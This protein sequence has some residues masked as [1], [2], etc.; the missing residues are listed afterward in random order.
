M[1]KKRKDP[2]IEGRGIYVITTDDGFPCKVGV[3]NDLKMRLGTLQTGNWNRLRA[4]WFTFVVNQRW[5]GSS[6]NVWAAASNAADAFELQIHEKMREL[7]LHL[8]GEWF[9]VDE[10]DCVEVIK[11]VA[12]DKHMTLTGAEFLSSIVHHRE[13][14]KEDL[15]AVKAFIRAETS[16]RAAIKAS[17]RAT[18]DQAVQKV[19]D[20]DSQISQDWHNRAVFG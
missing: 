18:L 19:L 4:S 3:S 20:S 9:A 8:S 11:R 12:A 7:D 10:E 1:A 2:E 17:S 14:P 15:Q 5:A 16:A 13:M 6:L